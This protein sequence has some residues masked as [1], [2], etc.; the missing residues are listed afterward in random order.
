MSFSPDGDNFFASFIVFE[1]GRELE[2]AMDK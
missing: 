1:W 2:S